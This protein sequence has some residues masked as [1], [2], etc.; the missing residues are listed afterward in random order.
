MIKLW[1]LRSSTTLPLATL[2]AHTEGVLSVAWCPSDST[3]VLSSGK[4]NKTILWDLANLQPVFE[5]PAGG[6]RSS[7]TDAGFVSKEGGMFGE[8][9]SSAGQKRYQV[10]W[11]PCLPAVISAC[12]FDRKIQFYSLVGAKSKLGRAPKWL[13]NPVGAFFAF[14]GKLVSFNNKSVTMT[15]YATQEDT[16]LSR[17]CD[18]FQAALSTGD[19]K[20]FCDRKAND[21]SLS[22]Q[23]RQV[24]SLMK[25]ICFEKNARE[26]LLCYLGFNAAVIAETVANHVTGRVDANRS[27]YLPPPPPPLGLLPPPPGNVVSAEELFG[28]LPTPPAQEGLDGALGFA[29][30]P[31]PP[32]STGSLSGVA[33]SPEVMELAKE[34]AVTALAGQEAEP[35]IRDALVVGNFAAAVDCCVEAGMMAEALLLAQCGEPDLFVRTQALFLE[36]QSAKKPFLKLLRAVIRNEFL[37]YVTTSDLD[38]WQDTLALLS[39]YGKNEEFSGLCEALGLRL[40]EERGD[41]QSATLCYMCATNVERTVSFWAS[42]LRAANEASGRLDYRAL[43]EFIEKAELFTLSNPSADVGEECRYYY[44]QYAFVLASLGRLDVAAK[45]IKGSGLENSV[46]R[47]RIFQ[48]HAPAASATS[49]RAPPFPFERVQVQAAAKKQPKVATASVPVS[50]STVEN[51][52]LSQTATRAGVSAGNT[53]PSAQQQQP[54]PVQPQQQLLPGWMQ[55]IDPSSGRPYYVNQA[56]QLSQWE[57]PLAPGPAPAPAVAPV[58]STQSNPIDN[59]G[60]AIAS[61]P[62]A[63]VT[64]LKPANTA[65]RSQ[66]FPAGLKDPRLAAAS[67]AGA[68]AVAA[69]TNVVAPASV[70]GGAGVGYHTGGYANP[71]S[72]VPVPSQPGPGGYINNPH[73]PSGVGGQMAKVNQPVAAPGVAGR[74]VAPAPVPVP[75]VVLPLPPS[76]LSI[77]QL[78]SN[79]S[80]ECS[81]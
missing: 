78:V 66:G 41:R 13:R 37:E 42:E 49:A 47:D 43:Q 76:V 55:V 79:L 35:L 39:T 36:K 63:Q 27:A 54:Q 57:P 8:L 7:A 48:A 58:P 51:K 67:A 14:G 53:L 81:L 10:S 33:S 19:Y 17:A 18:E 32:I 26:E 9:A 3:L 4:D 2:S 71:G 65:P 16:Y 62:T 61:A 80:G 22:E 64:S 68:S 60:Q 6:A 59:R 23:D 12:S 21:A 29:P 25:V 31:P 73:A 38:R 34:M 70:A 52:K 72:A 44:S 74:P 69:K 11:S 1:D 46:L 75:V 20:G 24:W 40:E 5:L 15:L 77:D 56:M 45:F 30:P 28:E 50:A